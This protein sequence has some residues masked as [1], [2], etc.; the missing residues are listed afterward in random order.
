MEKV[1]ENICTM[2]RILN[3]GN[4]AIK[5][6]FQ[7]LEK[8]SAMERD[9]KQ[10]F[11]YYGSPDWFAHRELDSRGQLPQDLPRGVLTEDAV[12]DLLTDIIR[13]RQEAPQLCDSL[14][15]EEQE[16]TP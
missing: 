6:L 1:I 2:E 12:Y 14:L 16:Q 5:Q 3:D 7:D 15:R 4:D 10:L 11:A 13:L 9:L 8:L